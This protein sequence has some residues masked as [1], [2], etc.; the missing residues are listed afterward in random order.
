MFI[1]PYKRPRDHWNLSL[2]WPQKFQFFFLSIF[3]NWNKRAVDEHLIVATQIWLRKEKTEN[4][5]DQGTIYT[6]SKMAKLCWKMLVWLHQRLSKVLLIS[7]KRV[8]K[9]PLNVSNT[10]AVVNPFSCFRVL[11]AMFRLLNASFGT[12]GC[13][14]VIRSSFSILPDLTNQSC[15]H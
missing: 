10:V 11:V 7:Y 2:P 5:W 4:F 15:N 14:F 1:N 8:R 6:R 13:S 9:T 3:F 12:F